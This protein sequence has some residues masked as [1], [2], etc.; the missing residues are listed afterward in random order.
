VVASSTLILGGGFGGIAA[1]NSLRQLVP[2]EHEIV[3]IDKSPSFHVGAGKTWVML[4]E[5]TMEQISRPRKNLLDR[6]IGFLE[7]DILSIDLERKVVATGSETLRWDYLVIALGA[8]L[9]P[10][11][12]PGLAE[13]AQT[14]YTLEGAQR[15]QDVLRDFNGG[16]LAILIPKMP[17]K[18]PPAPYEAAML[19]RDAFE[20]R[21]LADRVRIAI[22]T[23]EATPMAT[24]GAEM[25]QYVRNE[26][27]RRSIGFHPQKRALRIDS[28]GRRLSFEDGIEVGYDLLVA[29]PPHEAPKVVREAQLTN[30]SGWIP[31]DP[32]T[33]KV[34]AIR[35]SSDVYAV[36]DITSVL[37]PGRYKPDVALSLPKAGV[38]AE[39]HGRVAAHQIAGKILG[40]ESSETFD[41]RGHCYLEIGGGR[42]IKAD[43][44]FFELPH[45]IM[46]KQI[47]DEAQF[48]DKVAWVARHLNPVS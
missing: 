40:R 4:G 9:N 2:R 22:Y 10:A 29:V 24:A 12:V 6:G 11:S 48:R 32:L 1:A 30:Q 45:P 27:A 47:P 21:G 7:A 23:V 20:V 31:V 35:G 37:L 3:V 5:R 17:I 39:A 19:L 42:A 14:F 34:T 43:G 28:A 41:G 16:D 15:L 26:L 44:A 46:R 36:G 33:L 38:F 25:G 8:D 13:G 18:C